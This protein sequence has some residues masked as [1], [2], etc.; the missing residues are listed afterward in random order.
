VEEWLTVEEAAWVSRVQA[1]L[2][3]LRC[4][5]VAVLMGIPLGKDTKTSGLGQTA[6]QAIS[7]QNVNGFIS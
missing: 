7:R 1:E 3:A 2:H 4:V 5:Y 6:G